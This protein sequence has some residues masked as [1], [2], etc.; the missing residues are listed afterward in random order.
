MIYSNKYAAKLLDPR[1]THL[2]N[3][4]FHTMQQKDLDR[5]V[6]YDCKERPDILRWQQ[7]MEYS[8]IVSLFNAQ[9]LG[10]A[11]WVNGFMGRTALVH[12]CIFNPKD[13]LELGT[14][15]MECLRRHKVADSLVGITPVCYRHVWPL[16][17]GLGFRKITVVK[18][19]CYFARR[20]KYID[21]LVSQL[22]L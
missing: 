11:C 20:E 13:A 1:A 5:V 3:D 19:S 22:D 18:G 16:M 15:A 4:V 14:L 2:I 6:L 9:G 21:G 7:I 12:F 17:E 8:R 10:A